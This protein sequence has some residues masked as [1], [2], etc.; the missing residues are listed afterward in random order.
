MASVDK[1]WV[2]K[3][4]SC[5]LKGAGEPISGEIYTYDQ[6]PSP[7]ASL[8]MPLSLY[9]SV[10]LPVLCPSF[11]RLRLTQLR[12][13]GVL[14]RTHPRGSPESGAWCGSIGERHAHY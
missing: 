10:S 11:G 6:V 1:D 12:S 2:G 4:L 7:S 14:V 9:L 8:P 13:V 3:N 5:T